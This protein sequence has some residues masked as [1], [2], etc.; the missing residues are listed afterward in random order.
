[1]PPAIL[2]TALYCDDLEAARQFYTHKLELEVV[3]EVPGRHVFFQLANS[4]LL[5]FDPAATVKPSTGRFAVPEH[6]ATGNGH[7]CFST[8]P[9]G[10]GHWLNKVREAGIEIERELTWPNGARS[11]YFRDVAGNSLEFGEPK[12]WDL[13]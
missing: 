5:I 2:E 7:A 10:Y 4:V 3:A 8:A 6:G 11:F 9:L 12:L 13:E 1:M